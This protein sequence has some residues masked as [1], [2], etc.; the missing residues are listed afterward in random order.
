MPARRSLACLAL[1]AVA[2]CARPEPPAPPKADP[3]AIEQAI[4][5]K[6][7]DWNGYIAA[8][9]DSAIA[10]LYAD[11][12]V[13]MPPNQPRRT[14]ADI[15]TFWS[16]LW[17]IK[18]TMTISTDKVVASEAGDVAVEEGSFKLSYAGA[19]GKPIEDTGKY[20]VIW[21][22]TGNDWKV[23]RDIFNTDLPPA[24]PPAPKKN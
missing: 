9:D 1:A 11:D 24:P 17:V 5:A 16:G 2:A 6:G 12:A 21:R 10:A 8:Q 20:I 15:R 23:V 18:P 19:D 22:K 7:S 3:A 14:G 13:L 4:K